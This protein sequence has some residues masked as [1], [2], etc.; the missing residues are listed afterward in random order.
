MS[1][2]T[3]REKEKTTSEEIRERT[4]LIVQGVTAIAERREEEILELFRS[5]PDSIKKTGSLEGAISAMLLICQ[6]RPEQDRLE[7]ED[8]E[9]M[10]K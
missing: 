1:F 5:L 4:N 8:G 3:K 7:R 6:S 10:T 2:A 9:K